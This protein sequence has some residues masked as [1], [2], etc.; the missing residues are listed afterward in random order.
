MKGLKPCPFCGS[1]HQFIEDLG[2]KPASRFYDGK[3]WFVINCAD[4]EAGV[5][6]FG[7]EEMI[8]AW[9][10]RANNEV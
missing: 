6:G 1:K 5:R 2:W 8:A 10:R 9:N 4:C 3:H 7:R